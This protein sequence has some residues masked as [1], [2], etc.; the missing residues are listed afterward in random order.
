MRP[1]VTK[2]RFVKC[3]KFSEPLL[4]LMP[5][6]FARL[7]LK[8]AN[9]ESSPRDEKFCHFLLV[10]IRRADSRLRPSVPR[11]IK[12]RRGLGAAGEVSPS[13]YEGGL[14]HKG[15]LSRQLRDW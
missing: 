2:L 15:D 3:R 1:A 12:K 13:Q 10:E 9:I 6:P 14:S 11:P 4:R 8:S 5:E 7:G